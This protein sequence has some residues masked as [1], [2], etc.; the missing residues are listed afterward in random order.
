MNIQGKNI[1]VTGATGGIGK[2]VA[3]LLDEERANLIL[4]SK[5]EDELQSLSQSLHT[6]NKYYIC[7]LSSVSEIEKLASDIARD[8]DQIDVLVNSAG[9]GVYKPFEEL[10]LDEWNKSMNVN[11][12]SVFLLTQKLMPLLL[13]SEDS[14]VVNIGSGNGVDAVAGRSAYCTSK[15]ALRGLSLS[16][17]EEYGRIGNPTVALLTLGS[18]LTPFGP[19]SFEDKKLEMEKGKAYLL[20]E[21]VAEKI[22]DIIK[23]DDVQSEYVLYPTGYNK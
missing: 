15:F 13:K 10:S 19:L 5:T 12:N 22:I 16:L 7:N 1:I 4:V 8:F 6:A 9:V 14:V 2:E 21:S 17:S 18:V 23:S 3:K 11:V 20:P